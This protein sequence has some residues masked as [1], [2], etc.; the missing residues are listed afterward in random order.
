VF[1]ALDKYLFTY[2]KI[3]TKELSER[4][5]DLTAV[6][7]FKKE[8]VATKFKELLGKKSSSFLTSIMSIISQS[9]MLKKADPKTVYLAALTSAT[10]DLPINPNLWFAYI[11]PY[12]SRDWVKAQFQL[13]YKWFLQLALRSWQFKTISATPIY[14]WQLISSNPLTWYEFDW[15]IKKKWDPIWYVSY[16]SLINWFE[17]T[18]YMTIKELKDHWLKFSQSFKK[19]YWLRKDNFDAMAIKTVIKLLLSKYAPLSV[20][21]QKAFIADQ[22]VIQDENLD[23]IEYIDNKELVEMENNIDPELW[24]HRVDM[25]NDCKTLEELKECRKQNKPTD[26]SVFSLFKQREDELKKSV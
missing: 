12:N 7:I 26:K 14:E 2:Y 23:N 15:D 18:M 1:L 4:K 6:N 8:D 5:V 13:G 22:W 16:F 19:W 20:D 17:K 25:L 3:M 9:E 21:M 24:Q 11:L 10:L